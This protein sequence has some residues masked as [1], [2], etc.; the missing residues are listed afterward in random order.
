MSTGVDLSQWKKALLTTNYFI[1]TPY[2]LYS[3]ITNNTEKVNLTE[4][5]DKVNENVRLAILS[6]PDLLH[7]LVFHCHV[8]LPFLV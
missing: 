8:Q 4:E 3:L 7:T 2:T 1:I 5:F 6:E